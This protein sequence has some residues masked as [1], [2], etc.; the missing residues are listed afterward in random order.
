M[1]K[2]HRIL[3][4]LKVILICVLTLSG[5]VHVSAETAEIP[6]DYTLKEVV[7]LS[8]HNIRA[9]LSSTGSALSSATPETWHAWTSNPSE[10]SL[11]GGILETEMGQYFRKWSEA[12]G[13]IPENY[14]P[15][16]DEIR[17][18]ANAKQRTIATA[19]YFSSG[20]LP[21]ANVRIETNQTFNEMDP[22]FHPAFTFMNDAYAEDVKAQMNAAIP[23]LSKEYELVSNVVRYTES[24]GYQNGTLS[25]LVNGD[26][27]FTLE[28]NEEP[29]MK[30]SLK[31][32]TTLSDALVLQYYEEPDAE[33]AG[34]GRV[35][36]IEEWK[37]ITRIKETYNYIMFGTPLAAVN[38]AN[39]LLKEIRSELD[40][41]N[42]KFTFL[43]GHDSNIDSVLSA[44][45]AEDYT[46]P[47]T[48]EIKTPIGSKLVFEKWEDNT[49]EEYARIRMVYQST[50]QLRTMP[51]LTLEN[52]PV[53]YDLSFNGLTPNKDGLIPMEDLEAH[54]DKCIAEYDAVR[55]TYGIDKTSVPDTAVR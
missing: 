38:L 27:E 2:N 52:P 7:I 8:R 17:F 42:R 9:P 24:E 46:L 1:K 19:Q 50:D 35:H 55:K 32:A 18:Y 20:F 25:D 26:T 41:D 4:L 23:D 31:T 3:S 33:K 39:P 11:R 43:C 40:Q 28:L 36:S 51:Q 14:R 15:E 6:D 13:L 49:G 12:E 47:E 22:V 30:G 10:L 54:L 37:Q 53:S 16:G 48:L 34:F 5:T 44:M 21:V 45:D 29:K